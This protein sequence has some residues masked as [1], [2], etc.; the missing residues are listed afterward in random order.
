MNPQHF[1]EVLETVCM[2]TNSSKSK[3]AWNTGFCPHNFFDWQRK[4][5]PIHMTPFVMD[6]LKDYLFNRLGGR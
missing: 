6:K 4:G 2:S 1:K 3:V 5:V